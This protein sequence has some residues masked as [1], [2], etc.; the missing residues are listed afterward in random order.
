M[1]TETTNRPIC[2]IAA[3]IRKDW[4]AKIYFGAKPYLDAMLTLWNANDT[5]GC[6]D[7]KTQILYFLSNA[8]TYRG[9]NAKKY[10]AELK[11]IAG[12]K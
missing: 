10:K 6:E 9:E 4:G 5:Y 2:Q 12:V 1:S 11:K 8:S 3:D 7:A